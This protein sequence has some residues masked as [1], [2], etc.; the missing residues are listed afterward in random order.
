MSPVPEYL[1]EAGD[2]QGRANLETRPGELSGLRGDLR[3]T[4]PLWVGLGLQ[5]WGCH[6]EPLTDVSFGAEHCSV[7]KMLTCTS[8]NT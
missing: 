8:M 2:R 3:D 5:V 6:V 1:R 7:V 4:V